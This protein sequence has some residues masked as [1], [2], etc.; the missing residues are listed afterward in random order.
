MSLLE[1]D[2]TEICVRFTTGLSTTDGSRIDAVGLLVLEAEADEAVE[3]FAAEDP[4]ITTEAFRCGTAMHTHKR[5]E[6]QIKAK[7]NKQKK[8]RKTHEPIMTGERFLV[9]VELEATGELVR[10]SDAVDG[11][12]SIEEE[13]EAEEREEEEE[14]EP[15]AEEDGEKEEEEEAEEEEEEED[16]AAEDGIVVGGSFFFNFLGGSME[17]GLFA[18]VFRTGGGVLRRMSFS[19][20]VE[21]TLAV[22]CEEDE[23]EDEGGGADPETG[24]VLS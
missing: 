8:I 21:G 11:I 15:E 4:S 23:D 20:E 7:Q 3:V 19:S 18:V 2:K 24:P 14:E 22:E 13:E 1:V 5:R 6:H 10:E 12:E 17:M 9:V 16:E